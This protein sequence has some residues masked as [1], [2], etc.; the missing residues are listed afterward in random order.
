MAIPV[1]PV[2][3][4][5][6]I[7]QGFDSTV[8][9]IF[10]LGCDAGHDFIRLPMSVIRAGNLILR[11]QLRGMLGSAGPM[12]TVIVE[13]LAADVVVIIDALCSKKVIS[14]GHAFSHWVAQ[15]KA[16]M[17]LEKVPAMIFAAA[18]TRSGPNDIS[19]M[20]LV[21]VNV[22]PPIKTRLEAL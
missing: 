6:V 15:N 22:L 10:P 9:I 8:L 11:S 21:A 17:Y 7:V 2:A 18:Q 16:T 12:K 4:L 1:H 13:D 14:V 20:P 5:S 19:Q 3:G